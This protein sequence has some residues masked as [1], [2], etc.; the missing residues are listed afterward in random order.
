MPADG[1]QFWKLAEA[2]AESA[3]GVSDD[4]YARL[5]ALPGRA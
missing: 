1:G 3:S 4:P 5:R 2:E